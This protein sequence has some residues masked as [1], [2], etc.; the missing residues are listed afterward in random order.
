MSGQKEAYRSGTGGEWPRFNTV[1]DG[2]S[3]KNYLDAFAQRKRIQMILL[4]GIALK[5]SNCTEKKG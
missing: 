4:A 2:L 5:L 3:A 1:N